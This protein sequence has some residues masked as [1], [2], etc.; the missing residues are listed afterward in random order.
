MFVIGITGGIAS[1]K[2]MVTE[3]LGRRGAAILDAD[4]IGHAV[5]RLADVKTALH[6]RWGTAVF[7]AHA[8]ERLGVVDRAAV[9]RR[10]FA[11]APAGP[12]EL[13]FLERLTHPLISARIATRI[14]RHRQRGDVPAVVLDAPVLYKAGWE[15]YCDIILFVDAPFDVRAARAALRGWSLDQLQTRQQMQPSIEFQRARADQ[16]IDNGGV[17][18]ETSLRIDAFWGNLFREGK[19]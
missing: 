19:K 10:V 17:F 2:T 12:R 13:E 4:R 11:A 14:A 3:E 6:A 9:A 5:L 16:V 8:G 7:R 18:A 1:G 15:S